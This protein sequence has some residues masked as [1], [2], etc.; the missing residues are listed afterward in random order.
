MQQ[1]IHHV[2]LP[3]RVDIKPRE[4]RGGVYLLPIPSG[5]KCP[6]DC[7]SHRY[8]ITALLL[9]VVYG[10]GGGIGHLERLRVHHLVFQLLGGYLE[11]GNARMK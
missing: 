3:A 11:T 6:H 2:D 9:G 7:G 4:A 5:L 8:D 10:L 1:T